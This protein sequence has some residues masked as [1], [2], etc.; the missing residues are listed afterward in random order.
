MIICIISVQRI[1][2]SKWGQ[3]LIRNCDHQQR[4]NQ[5]LN[6]DVSGAKLDDPGKCNAEESVAHSNCTNVQDYNNNYY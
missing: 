4:N 1:A 5:I 6:S 2:E 3:T